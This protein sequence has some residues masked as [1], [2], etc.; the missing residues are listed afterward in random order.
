MST[1][2][3]VRKVK[4]ATASA[5]RKTSRAFAVVK[6]GSG[7]LFINGMPYDVYFPNEL[8]QMKVLEP[9]WLASDYISDVDIEV[10]VSGGG[11][12]SQADAVRMAIGRALVEY[13]GSEKLERIYR[14]YDRTIL[15]GDPRQREPKKYG[16]RRPRAR[17]QKSYR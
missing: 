17:V 3:S 11:F 10:R 7:R 12:M 13:T 6:K 14:E 8:V 4:M 15:K 5:S 2:K 1:A 16:G 9:I